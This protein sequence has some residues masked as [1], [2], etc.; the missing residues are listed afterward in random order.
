MIKYP[1][2]S[3]QRDHFHKIRF[4]CQ[5]QRLRNKTQI[6]IGVFTLKVIECSREVIDLKFGFGDPSFLHHQQDTADKLGTSSK[7]GVCW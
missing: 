5:V 3:K 6:F 7:G 4:D 1:V 2:Y